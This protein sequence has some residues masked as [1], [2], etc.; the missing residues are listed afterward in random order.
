MTRKKRLYLS[1]LI[2]LCLFLAVVLIGV[3]DVL[4]IGRYVDSWDNCLG[5]P[6]KEAGTYSLAY[7]FLKELFSFGNLVRLA[8]FSAALGFALWCL[9]AKRRNRSA[10]VAFT[11]FLSGFGI[12]LSAIPLLFAISIPVSDTMAFAVLGLAEILDTV[13]YPLG[14]ISFLGTAI[15]SAKVFISSCAEGC[16]SQKEAI[17]S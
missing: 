5:T 7:V 17:S 16:F 11:V 15:L 1:V 6:P 2:P 13:V 10:S 8:V 12:V 3:I 4:S 9:L 14:W